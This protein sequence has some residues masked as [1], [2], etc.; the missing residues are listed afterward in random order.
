MIYLAASW[1]ISY[2]IKIR[3]LVY[4][5]FVNR[6]IDCLRI[7]IIYSRRA[8]GTIMKFDCYFFNICPTETSTLILKGIDN[9]NQI[10]SRRFARRIQICNRVNYMQA[11]IPC[12]YFRCDVESKT[13]L[14]SGKRMFYG[15]WNSFGM[16][17]HANHAF[18]LDQ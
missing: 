12:L 10:L 17:Q 15:S 6:G 11:K 18:I 4:L 1:G 13:L 9:T 8:E 3:N 7:E 14:K 16:S 5:N 2:G